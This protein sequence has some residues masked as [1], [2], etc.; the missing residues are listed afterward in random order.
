MTEMAPNQILAN[1][2]LE[3]QTI[4]ERIKTA[5]LAISGITNDLPNLPKPSALQALQNLDVVDQTVLA[6]ASYLSELSQM[7]NNVPMIDIR[8]PISNIP[9]EDLEARLR[10]TVVNSN[11]PGGLGSPNQPELF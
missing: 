10:G 6:L 7:M 8:Q 5:E 1:V 4:S 3:L 9:L 2:A 11:R